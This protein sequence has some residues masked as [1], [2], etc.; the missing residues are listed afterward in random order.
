[1]LALQHSVINEN[2]EVI[3]IWAMGTVIYTCVLIVV[4]LK[5]CLESR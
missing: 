4:S 5:L 3:D 2:G 1:M